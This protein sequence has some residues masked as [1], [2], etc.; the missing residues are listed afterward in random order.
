MERI[1]LYPLAIKIGDDSSVYKSSIKNVITKHS[2]GEW[3]KI[4]K[5]FKKN[6]KEYEDVYGLK[7]TNI[8]RFK[9]SFIKVDV[10]IS[11][12]NK[13]SNWYEKNNLSG[14]F[15]GFINHDLRAS[16]H[17]SFYPETYDNGN[18]VHEFI[19]VEVKKNY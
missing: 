18:L 15:V 6:V 2:V 12:P 5:E 1:V 17:P 19:V 8:E 9:K 4:I 11:N 3:N 10:E 16:G 13:F 14:V 7:I